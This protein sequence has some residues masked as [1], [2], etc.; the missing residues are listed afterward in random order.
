MWFWEET[1]W[2]M[3]RGWGLLPTTDKESAPSLGGGGERW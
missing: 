3:G 2:K 1:G